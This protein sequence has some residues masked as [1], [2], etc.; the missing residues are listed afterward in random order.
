MHKQSLTAVST[1]TDTNFSS[2]HTADTTV[3]DVGETRLTKIPAYWKPS[4]KLCSRLA[5]SQC[6]ISDL[7][8]TKKRA[9]CT[10][11]SLTLTSQTK[12]WNAAN[13]STPVKEFGQ[14]VPTRTRNSSVT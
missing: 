9:N 7:I 2:A 3:Q 10:S 12:H 6:M 5:T 11:R 14:L 4:T 13:D 1:N 8:P